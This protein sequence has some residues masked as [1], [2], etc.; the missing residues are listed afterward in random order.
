MRGT[1][2]IRRGAT[3]LGDLTQLTAPAQRTTAVRVGLALA[4]AATLAGAILLASSAG[5][6]RAAVLPVGAKTGVL[7]LDVSA[8][9][10]GPPFERVGTVVRGLVA[11]NQA[12][13]LVMFSDTAYELLPPN[14]PPSALQQFLRFFAPKSV[15]KGAPVFGDSPWSQFSGG[16]RISTGLVVGAEALHRADITH[17]SLVLMSDLNDSQNDR[18]PLVAEATALRRGAYP[19]PDHP[20]QCRPAG[21]P[22]LRGPLRP[23][24]VRRA[25]GVQA[26]VEAQRR[27]DRGRFALGPA[28]GRR[29]PRG[30]T[31][32]ERAPQLP[33][34]SGVGHMRRLRRALPLVAAA[35]LLGLAAVLALFASDIRAWQGAVTNSDLRF[36]AQRSHIGLWRTPTVLPGDPARSAA[37]PRRRPLV[38]AGGAALLA[39]ASRARARAARPDLAATRAD[40]ESQLQRLMTTAATA[41]ERSTAANLLGVMTVTAPASSPTQK[42]EISFATHYFKQAVID[43]PRNIDAK[44]NLELLLR[45][46]RPGKNRLDQD[47]RGGFGFGGAN[48][49]GVVGGGL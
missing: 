28:R 12:M 2:L 7:I 8:S 33:S 23:G 25:T 48:G 10:A 45:I 30:A 24:L 1:T 20:G 39:A 31:R 27:A 47:A 26:D 14:S 29:R 38:S 11:A 36:R 21:R 35:V 3:R 44:L 22:A 41:Q 34:R 42:S 5:S 6:G 19:G 49:V 43:D 4:L 40:A 15:T 37:R 46:V 13:G 9:V 16:T 17:G 18:D 32:R